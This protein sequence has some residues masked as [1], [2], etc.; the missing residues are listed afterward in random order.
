MSDMRKTD[1]RTYQPSLAGGT[2][3][4]SGGANGE[5]TAS[6]DSLIG[7]NSVTEYK[8]GKLPMGGGDLGG[9]PK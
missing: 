8:P 5:K 3:T 2:Q 6:K 7:K 9:K 1:P 4:V